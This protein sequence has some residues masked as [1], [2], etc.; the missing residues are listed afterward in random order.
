ME[1]TSQKQILMPLKKV[2]WS[3][4][5]PRRTKQVGSVTPARSIRWEAR[6]RSVS[7]FLKTYFLNMFKVH[8][9]SV[10]TFGISACV[11][12]KRA[13][14]SHYY[15]L[16][17]V[18][19]WTDATVCG[20]LNVTFVNKLL[21]SLRGKK[22]NGWFIQIDECSVITYYK[23]NMT[24]DAHQ[25]TESWGNRLKINCLFSCHQTLTS[26]LVVDCAAE[27]MLL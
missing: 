19:K 27:H 3:S 16:I 7:P 6:W 4:H 14:L 1:T 22:L 5:S 12:Q 17:N 2:T 18:H 10:K 13:R 25:I 11:V 24:F 23:I 26:L 21:E 15:A 9:A 20:F 8:G